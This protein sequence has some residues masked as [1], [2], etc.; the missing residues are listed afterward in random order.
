MHRP[1]KIQETYAYSQQTSHLTAPRKSAKDP[2]IS[3]AYRLRQRLDDK[4]GAA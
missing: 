4:Q 2:M 3:S 1:G